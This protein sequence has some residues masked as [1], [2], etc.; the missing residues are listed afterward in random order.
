MLDLGM[1]TL[2]AKGVEEGLGLT[3]LIIQRLL[4]NWTLETQEGNDSWM[5]QLNNR[6][7]MLAITL[8]KLKIYARTSSFA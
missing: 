2:S 1:I 7:I 8:V 5:S 3:V 4:A 6:A